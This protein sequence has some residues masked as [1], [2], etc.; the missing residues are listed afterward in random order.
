MRATDFGVPACVGQAES[1]VNSRTRLHDEVSSVRTVRLHESL[2]PGGGPADTNDRHPNQPTADLPVSSL[3]WR[4]PIRSVDELPS[5]AMTQR[6]LALCSTTA[7]SILRSSW[8]P[9]GGAPAFRG[10]HKATTGRRGT[11]ARSGLR[12]STWIGCTSDW[13]PIHGNLP[14]RRVASAPRHDFRRQKNLG[15]KLHSATSPARHW[16]A[17]PGGGS[18]PKGRLRWLLVLRFLSAS[19]CSGH[20]IGSDSDADVDRGRSRGRV[21]AHATDRPHLVTT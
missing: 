13:R 16:M 12:S 17:A 2:Q 7:R 18:V 20:A 3:I 21:R 19:T 11:P 1:S 8:S 15:T 14:P 9:W 6:F 4:Y 5:V 10:C